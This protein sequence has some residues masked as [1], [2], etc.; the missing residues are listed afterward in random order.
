MPSAE[1]IL[2]LGAFEFLWGTAATAML[3]TRPAL[4]NFSSRWTDI[5]RFDQGSTESRLTDFIT[6]PT[7][8]LA[9]PYGTT[10]SRKNTLPPL[11]AL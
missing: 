1:R 2:S 9:S 5:A 7:H 10:R 6:D 4:L 8:D 3:Q 11:A